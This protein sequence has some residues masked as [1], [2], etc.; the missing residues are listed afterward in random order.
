MKP[1]SHLNIMLITL[2]TF[3]P[4]LAS[5][6][7]PAGVHRPAS[8]DRNLQVFACEKMKMSEGR[9]VIIGLA[10]KGITLEQAILQIECR[11]EDSTL[12]EYGAA[13][14]AY[15]A[16]RTLLKFLEKRAVALNNPELLD[17]ILNRKDEKGTTV[18]DYVR[19][20]TER[21][22]NEGIISQ[23]NNIYDLFVKYGAKHSKE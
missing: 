7:N 9:G 16:I 13:F 5:S 2:C 6:D 8:I 17:E 23:Y 4:A 10:K 22:T 12:L 19:D 3:T 18:L 20:V 21:S 15:S 11:G 14:G 1:L